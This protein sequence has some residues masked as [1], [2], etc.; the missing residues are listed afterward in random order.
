MREKVRW[1]KTGRSEPTTSVVT[2]KLVVALI[3]LATIC[4]HY[5]S[6]TLPLSLPF[7]SIPEVLSLVCLE[8]T[9]QSKLTEAVI[10]KSEEPQLRNCGQI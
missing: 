8:P 2:I 6:L 3:S 5:S 7:P 9:K 10:S 4:N 1:S